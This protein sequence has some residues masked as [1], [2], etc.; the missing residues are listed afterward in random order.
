MSGMEKKLTAIKRPQSR[1]GCHTYE[2][3]QW[4]GL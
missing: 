3:S 1:G 2:S 4:P